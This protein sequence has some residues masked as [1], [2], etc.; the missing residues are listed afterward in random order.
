MSDRD[1][2]EWRKPVI[3]GEDVKPFRKEEVR[4]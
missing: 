4:P 1:G 3:V 2:A